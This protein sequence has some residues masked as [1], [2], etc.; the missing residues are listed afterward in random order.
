MWRRSLA[1]ELEYPDP[2]DTDYN[3]RAAPADAAAVTARSVSLPQQQA[4]DGHLQALRALSEAGAITIGDAVN[5]AVLE[6][7][8]RDPTTL[9]HAEDLQVT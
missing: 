9:M 3:G 5:L 6:E 1:K 8:L 7:M 2:A 4:L